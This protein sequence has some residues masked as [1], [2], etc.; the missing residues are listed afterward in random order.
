MI[1]CVPYRGAN[2]VF[3]QRSDV[4]A[5]IVELP[6][7]CKTAGSLQLPV[8]LR[9]S[10]SITK[11][12]STFARESSV[13]LLTLIT[14]TATCTAVTCLEVCDDQM[15]SET[16]RG[17]PRLS[18]PSL[19]AARS[20]PVG[21]ELPPNLSG[22]DMLAVTELALLCLPCILVVC[23]HLMTRKIVGTDAVDNRRTLARVYQS[24]PLLCVCH[25]LAS[26]C[27]TDHAAP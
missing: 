23:L 3:L 21:P 8:G 11:H 5:E 24:L 7:A 26:G 16:R 25:L 27:K 1:S 9:Q 14:M 13:G 6:V 15:S 22:W 17:R 18:T 2:A 12:E 20:S 19:R 4:R 10:L